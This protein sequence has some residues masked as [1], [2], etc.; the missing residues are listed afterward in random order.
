MVEFY[1]QTKEFELVVEQLSTQEIAVHKDGI[2]E[3]ALQK[4]CA[5]CVENNEFSKYSNCLSNKPNEELNGTF[6]LLL[7]SDA[8]RRESQTRLL[9]QSF[10]SLLLLKNAEV[11]H[12]FA[13]FVRFLADLHVEYFQD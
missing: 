3:V 4:F 7:L 1:N 10:K 12:E 9:N 8:W 13:K 2:I 11:C 5:T 6:T